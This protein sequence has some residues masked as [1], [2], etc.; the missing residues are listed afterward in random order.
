M[1]GDDKYNRWRR[2]RWRN[3]LIFVRAFN[4]KL[5]ILA[6]K[7]VKFDF[8]MI[9]KIDMMLINKY[10][11]DINDGLVD[12]SYRFVSFLFLFIFKYLY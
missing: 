12:L 11:D 8:N 9:K 6:G 10:K 3:W 2:Y 5:R 7:M 4:K 1:N